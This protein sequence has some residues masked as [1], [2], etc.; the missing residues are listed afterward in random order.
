VIADDGELIGGYSMTATV[1]AASEV[2]LNSR[3]HAITGRL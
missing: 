2:R 1:E 3:V